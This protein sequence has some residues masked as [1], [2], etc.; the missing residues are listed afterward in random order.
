MSDSVNATFPSYRLLAY[1]E[2]SYTSLESL[3][4]V[5]F[6]GV[7]VLF[8]PDHAGTFRQARGLAASASWSGRAGGFPRI[9]GIFGI[10][11]I[12]DIFRF[13]F[14]IFGIFGYS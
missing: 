2:G 1:T 8:I 4:T 3:K 6:S 7:P 11:R 10:F 12:L 5:K 9:F 14:G 13:F